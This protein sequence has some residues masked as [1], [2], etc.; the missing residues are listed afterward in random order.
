MQV[1][2]LGI[3]EHG[4]PRI[5]WV[6]RIAIS[7]LIG[8]VAYVLLSYLFRYGIPAATSDVLRGRLIVLSPIISCT[9]T[10]CCC[11]VLGLRRQKK[12]TRCRKCG[13]I[14]RGLSEPRCSECGEA[15]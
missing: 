9:L 12:E 15:I 1:L 11:F 6:W 10:T 5:H 3:G 4:P 7:S 8:T 14:L 2:G 13:Y